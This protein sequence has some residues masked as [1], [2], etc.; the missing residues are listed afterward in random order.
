MEVTLRPMSA[1]ELATWIRASI[2]EYA[3]GLAA[4]AALPLDEALAEAAR[5]TEELLP[6]G[7]DTEGVL[8]RTAVVGRRAVG[9]TCVNLPGGDRPDSAWVNMLVVDEGQRGKGYG[10]AI[11]LAAEAELVRLGVPRLG[12][13]VFG[14]NIS[15]MHLYEGLGFRMTS[16]QMSRTVAR[17]DATEVR[18]RP[19]S[20]AEYASLAAVAADGFARSLSEASGLPLDE[21]QTEAARRTA[22]L[23]P[24]GLHTEGMLLW[25][26]EAGGQTVG[27]IWVSLP[28]GAHPRSAWVYMI[29][30]DESQRGKGY[31]RAIMLAA[32]A[33]L[34][35]LRVPRLGLNVFGANTRAIYLYEGLG[36]RMTSQQMTRELAR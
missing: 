16:Q 11:M 35:R 28:G 21:A 24:E 23:V 7:V 30:V 12:L 19:M 8:L 26:A 34:V 32:E 18:L 2:E 25:T 4:A 3:L 33:E 6:D 27:W 13:T 31:G 5:R 1:V 20:E 17:D 36:F 14:D 29:A 9:W 22:Q 15:A 10:R